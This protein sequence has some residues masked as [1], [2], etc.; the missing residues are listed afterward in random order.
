MNIFSKLISNAPTG[1]STSK[2]DK[3]RGCISPIIPTSSPETFMEATR[4]L[5]NDEW[6]VR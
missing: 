6:S 2:R 5:I 4:P 1:F 3:I